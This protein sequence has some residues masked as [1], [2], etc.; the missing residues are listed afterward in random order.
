MSGKA[1]VIGF[2]RTKMRL[3]TPMIGSRMHTNSMSFD[4]SDVLMK[5]SCTKLISL[6]KAKMPHTLGKASCEIPH[7]FRTYRQNKGLD[8]V[9]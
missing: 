5:R 2:W 3:G 7:L 8:H 9:A 1:S 4:P 6:P